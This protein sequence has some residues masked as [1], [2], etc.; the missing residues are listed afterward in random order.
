MQ[1]QVTIDTNTIQINT[2]KFWQGNQKGSSRTT[3]QETLYIH[4]SPVCTPQ[5]VLTISLL[6][7]LRHVST[8][9]HEQRDIQHPVFDNPLPETPAS[10]H[11][12]LNDN[13]NPE[14]RTAIRI[15]ILTQ[16]HTAE[17]VA[18]GTPPRLLSTLVNNMEL[19]CLQH[20]HKVWLDRNKEAET[21]DLRNDATQRSRQDTPSRR[22]TLIN[23]DDTEHRQTAKWE[24]DRHEA[25][26]RLQEWKKWGTT[27][28]DKVQQQQDTMYKRKRD[29]T[30]AGPQKKQKITT[31]S[32]KRQ[33]QALQPNTT[34]Q[35]FQQLFIQP[36]AAQYSTATVAL[37]RTPH[38]HAIQSLS[39]HAHIS[40]A[41]IDEALILLIRPRLPPNTA[42]LLCQDSYFMARTNMPRHQTRI[43]NVIHKHSTTLIPL[44]DSA[45]WFN[46]TF[47]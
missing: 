33:R 17:A 12:T 47:V 26:G 5:E 46:I 43:R 15:G 24:H 30:T 28:T 4:M 2:G 39:G 37:T 40:S 34:E 11:N 21:D 1:Q 13:A 42:L 29:S 9:A 22:P 16:Q 35:Q 20:S 27:K 36:T 31:T 44:F 8:Y 25:L 6:T 10:I 3:N 45:H 18:K 38:A 19:T 32:K 41:A 14:K 23:V 7:R